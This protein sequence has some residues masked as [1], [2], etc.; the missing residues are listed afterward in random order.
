MAGTERQDYKV[1]F[2]YYGDDL[3]ESIA[4][5]AVNQFVAYRRFREDQAERVVVLQ[6]NDV[7]L[8]STLMRVFEDYDPAAWDE[9]GFKEAFE[10]A[11]KSFSLIGRL[12][13]TEFTR[14]ASGTE[15]ICYE[16]TCKFH[17]DGNC[18]KKNAM[19]FDHNPRNQWCMDYVPLDQIKENPPYPNS[20]K[21]ERPLRE[22]D[23]RIRHQALTNLRALE[24]NEHLQVGY[25]GLASGLL[26]H[27]ETGNVELQIADGDDEHF[28]RSP[29]AMFAI[30]QR[31]I[32]HW[33]VGSFVRLNRNY[34]QMRSESPF[35][36]DAMTLRTL[37]IAV[38]EVAKLPYIPVKY[39]GRVDTM[40][41][42]D[43]IIG[44]QLVQ[45]PHETIFTPFA[46]SMIE[47]HKKFHPNDEV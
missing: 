25:T 40:L 10:A 47:Q 9:D 18:T 27:I 5:L 33:A 38:L 15:F 14:V 46:S 30:G 44:H 26:M 6:S 31:P 4:T 35:A 43:S 1:D 41:E 29:D 36:N 17:S 11:G 3:G 12:P 34:E 37:A 13:K 7:L 45:A 42:V 21:A 39:V 16:E 24:T 22:E 20:A 23:Y 2:V 32:G 19:Q 28:Q 8:L